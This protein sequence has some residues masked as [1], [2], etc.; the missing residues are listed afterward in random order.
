MNGYEYCVAF[1]FARINV[2]YHI[3][4]GTCGSLATQSAHTT[5]SNN[6]HVIHETV[7]LHII[8]CNQLITPFTFTV[9]FAS[10]KLLLLLVV[11][12]WLYLN[13]HKILFNRYSRYSWIAGIFLSIS[14]FFNAIH[15]HVMQC[16]RFASILCCAHINNSL[17]S[18][19]IEN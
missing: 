16:I 2:I 4:L 17:E 8:K 13:A 15:L 1:I 19:K 18:C 7:Y 6:F 10:N 5:H 3:V 14:L 9:C 11:F 12:L